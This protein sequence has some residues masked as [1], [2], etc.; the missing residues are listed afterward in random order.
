MKILKHIYTHLGPKNEPYKEPLN[1]EVTININQE[2]E[3]ILG[4]CGRLLSSSKSA[5]REFYPDHQVF[6]N[7]CL[8]DSNGTEIWFGDIDLTKENRK[9]EKAR[10]LFDN[11]IYLTKEDP[12][13]FEGFAPNNI[14]KYPKEDFI[15]IV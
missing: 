9:L 6:F 3:K 14:E 11:P 5:Y 15:T 13:R 7:A 2:V 1:L 8:W 4:P 12:Y 10:N